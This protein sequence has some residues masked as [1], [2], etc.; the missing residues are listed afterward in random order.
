MAMGTEILGLAGTVSAGFLIFCA[1]R[2]LKMRDERRPLAEFLWYVSGLIPLA[3][4]SLIWASMG[5]QPVTPQRI[6]L[7][8]IGAAIGGCGLLAVGEMVRPIALA[9]AQTPTGG[10]VVVQNSIGDINNN[11]GIITQGQSGGTNVIVSKP[12]PRDIDDQ[13]KNFI[14]EHFPDKSKEMAPMVLAGDDE[15]ERSRFASQIEDFLR[16]DGY[17]LRPRAYFL[18]TGATPMGVVID[19]YSDPTAIKVEV[20]VNNRQ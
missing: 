16:S 2:G 10:S 4:V 1:N 14:R 5:D 15:P 7:F 13:F 11:R 3:G 19:Q 12:P 17:K 20:G 6:I 18:A 8:I 9:N